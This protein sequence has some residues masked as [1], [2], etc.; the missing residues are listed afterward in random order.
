M[1]Q[2]FRTRLNV[3]KRL[4]RQSDRINIFTIRDTGDLSLCLPHEDIVRRMPLASQEKSP[5]LKLNYT[6]TLTLDFKAPELW[7]NKWQFFMPPS[8]QYFV[9]SILMDSGRVLLAFGW[10]NPSLFRTIPYI[11]GYVVSLVS[12]Y[13][14][15]VVLLCHYDNKK[16]S[17][18]SPNAS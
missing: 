14:I 2:Y 12:N 18:T 3:V 1:W 17:Y 15:L 6:R 11:T 5:P 13:K 8:L 9:M 7:E 10:Y 4:G 16:C